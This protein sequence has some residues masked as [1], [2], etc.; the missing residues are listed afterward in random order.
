MAVVGDF[1]HE[2]GGHK[3]WPSL[4]WLDYNSFLVDS[5]NQTYAYAGRCGSLSSTN[6]WTAGVTASTTLLPMPLFLN[7]SFTSFDVTTSAGNTYGA[8]AMPTGKEGA[9]VGAGPFELYTTEFDT[10]INYAP[11]KPL[12]APTATQTSSGAES[13]K[14]YN[15]RKWTGGDNGAI[16][17]GT[18]TIVGVTS[19][20]KK[21]ASNIDTTSPSYA[22]YKNPFAPLTDNLAFWTYFHPGTQ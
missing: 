7:R 20:G 12:K 21:N 11:N 18:D 1:T 17:V 9:L 8:T 4:S 13:G 15:L 6:T 14:L 5:N 10:S 19:F 2:L 16:T 3:G 22:N